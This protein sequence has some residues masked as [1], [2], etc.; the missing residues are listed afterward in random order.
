MA[1][2]S[3]TDPCMK[4][5]AMRNDSP[6]TPMNRP[7]RSTVPRPTD[8]SGAAPS[9]RTG[10]DSGIFTKTTTAQAMV[11]TASSRNPAR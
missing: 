6:T 2:G 7:S 9:E 10:R 1:T 5:S 8:S 3:P 4:I 11:I